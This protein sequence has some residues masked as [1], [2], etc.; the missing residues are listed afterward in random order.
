MKSKKNLILIY[1]SIAKDVKACLYNNFPQYNRLFY[2]KTVISYK[3][4][5]MVLHFREIINLVTLDISHYS[6][7]KHRKSYALGS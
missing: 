3:V 4:Y 5:L 6:V 1:E 7:G 2:F